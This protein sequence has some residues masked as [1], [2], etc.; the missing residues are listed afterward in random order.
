[1][2]PLIAVAT[3]YFGVS[4]AEAHARLLAAKTES[5]WHQLTAQPLRFVG[6]NFANQV[7]AYVNGPTRALPG[8][9]FHGDITRSGVR[10][11]TQ[12]AAH[13]WRTSLDTTSAKRYGI[14]LFD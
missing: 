4:P 14:G 9:P 10:R 6:C 2:A 11:G 1:V 5:A 13:A 7:V 12:L 3:H 8:R